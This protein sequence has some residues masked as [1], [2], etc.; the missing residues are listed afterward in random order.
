MVVK[1]FIGKVGLLSVALSLSVVGSAYA[2]TKSDI[3]TDVLAKADAQVV[4]T[5]VPKTTAWEV[6]LN[7]NKKQVIP[8]SELN[9]SGSFSVFS[10]PIDGFTYI[11]NGYVSSAAQKNWYYQNMGTVRIENNL[12]TSAS[13]NYSQTTSKESQWN[14]GINISGRTEVKASFLAKLEVELGGSWG[15][16]KTFTSGTSYG[17]SQ[18][19]P[20]KTT[21]YITAYSVGGSSHG[22]LE[23]KKYSPGGT[24]V[25]YYF[26]SA[27]GT[28]VNPYD[29]NI[30]IQST[31]PIV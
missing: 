20:A 4:P 23:Y 28:A 12:T 31:V 7:G 14:V 3:P 9:K 17:I 27:A 24:L 30:V 2:K 16:S 10:V 29:S 6:D 5:S 26:E 13:A 21:A 18:V 11:F 22:N 25:G 1:N 8:L 19:I 15:I